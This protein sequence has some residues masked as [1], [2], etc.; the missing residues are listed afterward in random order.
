VD[1]QTVLKPLMQG[2]AYTPDVDQQVRMLART[3]ISRPNMERLADRPDLGLGVSGSVPG[4]EHAIAQ[5]T[6]RIRFEPVGGAANLYSVTYRD[7]DGARAKRVVE[8]M[9]DLFVSASSVGKRRD[10]EEASQFIDEQIKAY[11]TKLVEA[12][13]RLKEFKVRHFG[14]SGVA[15]Q[16]FFARMSTLSD[17][18]SRLRLDLSAAEQSRDAYR[19]ELA[20]ENPQLPSDGSGLT[21]AAP[22]SELDARIESQKKLLDEMLRRFTDEHPDV[23]ATRR[24]IAQLEQQREREAAAKAAAV[25]AGKKTVAAT[26]PIYQK[27]RVSLAEAEAQVAS[28]RSQLGFKQARLEEAR[29]MAS[30]VPQI[31]AELAQLNRDYDIINKNYQGLVARRESASLGVKMDESSRLAEFRVI[32]PP[33][34]SPKAAFPSRTHLGLMAVALALALGIAVPLAIDYVWPT[35]KSAAAL[36]AA[37]GRQVLGSVT[38]AITDAGRGSMRGQAIGVAAA[39]GCLLVV[40]ATWLFWVAGRINLG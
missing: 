9:I 35:F 20:D 33:R 37:T 13:N 23:I 25:A 34:V 36:Q 1:T 11:E 39:F 31:E 14:S 3:L 30:R 5:L 29:A 18:V 28:L 15:G 21:P 12:E 4:R 16:D 32:E 8:A 26:S 19:R 24:V 6:Q 2:L 7:V 17:E 10:S 27:L 38:L 40:Q 22:P